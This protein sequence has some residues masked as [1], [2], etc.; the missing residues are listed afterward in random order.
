[1]SYLARIEVRG[2]AEA[3]EFSGLL[4]LSPGLQVISARNAY[5]K[6]LAVQAVAWSLGLEAI[7][8][9]ADNDPIRLPEAV[10]E[11]LELVGHE[12]SAVISSESIITIRDDQKRQL[13]IRRAIKGGE[14]SVVVV[15]E[16]SMD[17]K[18]RESKLLARKLTM[19]DEHGGFQRFLFEWLNW[20]RLEVPSYRPGGSEVYLENVAPLFYIDQNEGWSNIQ[21]L[22]IARYSQ[23]EIGESPWSTYWALRTPSQCVSA[24]CKRPSGRGN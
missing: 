20:P 18:T 1:M 8:G 16:T 11:D 15:R 4:E 21:A 5:G 14:R 23:Q 17:G 3:G 6:S 9:N 12:K 24:A 2:R 7:F 19:K 22:Q 13:E 10:R